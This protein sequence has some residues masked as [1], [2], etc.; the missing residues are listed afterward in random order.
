MKR[1]GFRAN[2]G[3]ISAEIGKQPRE[4]EK[5]VSARERA[6][7]FAKMIRRPRLRV[8]KTKE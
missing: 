4:E 1:Y 7:E 2:Q 6:A 5:L 8:G 3:N